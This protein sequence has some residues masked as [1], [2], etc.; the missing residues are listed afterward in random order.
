MAGGPGLQEIKQMPEG[1]YRQLVVDRFDR[2]TERMDELADGQAEI[3]RKLTDILIQA[4]TTNGRVN[5]LELWRARIAG[6]LAVMTVGMPVL[7]FLLQR[8]F[9]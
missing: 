6:A 7:L 9:E 5:A 1:E 2:G 3:L 4:R 8:A